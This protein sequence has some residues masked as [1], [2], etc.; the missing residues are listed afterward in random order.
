[1]GWTIG[2]GVW[3]R[4]GHLVVLCVSMHEQPGL[5][6]GWHMLAHFDVRPQDVAKL[7]GCQPG[8]GCSSRC[9]LLLHIG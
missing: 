9:R 3:C 5:L 8:A 4:A 7:R 6:V 2:A 1:M